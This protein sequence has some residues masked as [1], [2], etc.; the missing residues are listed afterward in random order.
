MFYIH[1]HP[2][3]RA[4]HCS[5]PTLSTSSAD[6]GS[7][8]YVL[9]SGK[10]SF[11]DIEHSEGEMYSLRNL[12][13][14]AFSYSLFICRKALSKFAVFIFRN[15]IRMSQRSGDLR[16]LIPIKKIRLTSQNPHS[17]FEVRSHKD[18]IQIVGNTGGAHSLGLIKPYGFTDLESADVSSLAHHEYVVADGTEDGGFLHAQMDTSGSPHKMMEHRG[19]PDLLHNTMATRSLVRS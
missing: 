18:L 5:F 10:E 7:P 1:W 6:F 4:K 2:K 19:Y 17:H 15:S 16:A 13:D 14:F 11:H 12:P 3:A 9:R 8:S